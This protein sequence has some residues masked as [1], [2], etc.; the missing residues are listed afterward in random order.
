MAT[1]LTVPRRENVREANGFFILLADDDAAIR[2][3]AGKVLRNQGYEVLEAPDGVEA[4]AL[5]GRRHG[6]IHVLLT[7]WRMPRLGG[8]GLIRSLC[9]RRPETAV[10][11]MS[12]DFNADPPP[13]AT[14]LPKPF[15]ARDL[16][17]KVRDALDSSQ[18]LGTNGTQFPGAW[19]EM[20]P[21]V[22]H[23][24]EPA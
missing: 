16:V 2:S 1:Q 5:A 11:I 18:R 13:N 7:D 20:P 10:L 19:R 4:L 12:A 23:S 8:E 22:L 17:K 21:V 9:A 15:T 14:V 6:P 24:H 3:L